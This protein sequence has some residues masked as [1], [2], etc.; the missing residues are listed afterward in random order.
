MPPRLLLLLL[1]LL[2]LRDNSNKMVPTQTTGTASSGV[3]GGGHNNNHKH[4]NIK[5]DHDHPKHDQRSVAVWTGKVVFIVLMLCFGALLGYASFRVLRNTESNASRAQFRSIAERALTQ[6]L[7][8]AR[9]DQM[10][11]ATMAY[12]VS[13][14]LPDATQWPFVYIDDFQTL[15]RNHMLQFTSPGSHLVF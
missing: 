6:A 9:R 11:T 13:R 14:L 3:G 5:N 8:N 1:F 7:A 2:L 12:T 10:A 15:S 4:H